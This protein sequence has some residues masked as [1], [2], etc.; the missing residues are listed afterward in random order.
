M[1]SPSSPT[2]SHDMYLAI[3]IGCGGKERGGEQTFGDEH[4]TQPPHAQRGKQK[5]SV[6]ARKPDHKTKTRTKATPPISRTAHPMASQS[7]P[8]ADI[9]ATEGG[10]ALGSATRTLR[11]L[12]RRLPACCL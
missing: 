11:C 3:V 7:G 6:S 5:A 9:G 10:G 4:A 12:P 1:S 2:P 8:Y